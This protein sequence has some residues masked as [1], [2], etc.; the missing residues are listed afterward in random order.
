MPPTPLTAAVLPAFVPPDGPPS[1]LAMLRHGLSDPAAIIPAAIYHQFS[2]KLPGRWS[3]LVVA[4]PETVRRILLDQGEAFGR[5]R[6]CGGCCAVPGDAAS[7]PPK[8]P[9]GRPNAAPPRLPF[10]PTPWKPRPPS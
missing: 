7:P 10:G 5:T 9:T 2:V 8:A 4:E 1:V 6:S 3:P